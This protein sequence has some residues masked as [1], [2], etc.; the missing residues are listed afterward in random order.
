MACMSV[1]TPILLRAAADRP[2]AR[3]RLLLLTC[4]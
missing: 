1:A 2:A 3:A 4:P